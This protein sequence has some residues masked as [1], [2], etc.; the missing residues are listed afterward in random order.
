MANFNLNKSIIGGRLTAT[1][2]LKKTIDGIS[3]TSFTVAVNRRI[4]TKNKETRTD[5]INVMAWRGTAEFICKHF[6]KGNSICIE[7]SIQTRNWTDDKG[8]KHYVTEVLADEVF[9]VDSK[10]EAVS[11]NNI[12]SDNSF[13]F[14]EITANGEDDDLPF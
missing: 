14:T 6:C 3:T 12:S 8:K 13:D 4:K 9:F 7:G 10:S 5:F 11:L 2:E 1:P